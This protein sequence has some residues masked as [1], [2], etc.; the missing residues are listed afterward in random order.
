MASRRTT[1]PY[2]VLSINSNDTAAARLL[3]SGTWKALNC[4]NPMANDAPF[5]Q[6]IA[7]VHL[8]GTQRSADTCVH[9]RNYFISNYTQD[10]YMLHL[11]VPRYS[12]TVLK[13]PLNPNSINQ[14][15]SESLPCLS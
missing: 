8:F 9:S 14:S 10:V 3:Q 6:A 15:L 13:V 12:L 11:L 5:H 2:I 4:V 1:G 7:S